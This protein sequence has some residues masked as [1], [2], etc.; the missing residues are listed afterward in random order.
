MPMTRTTSPSRTAGRFSRADMP[1]RRAARFSRTS[2]PTST[3]RM[4]GPRAGARPS[5]YGLAGGWLQRREQPK[6]GPKRV[7]ENLKALV[8]GLAKE[9]SRGSS[10]KR[11]SRGGKAGGIALASAAAGVAYKNRDKLMGMLRDKGSETHE[12]KTVSPVEAGTR[13]TTGAGD[14]I[15]S[16]NIA[17]TEPGNRPDIPPPG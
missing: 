11:R 16:G 10:S 8:P 7:V 12:D 6:S 2:A 14:P 1:S 13:P 5:R 4:G 9:V 3:R 15:R 17:P